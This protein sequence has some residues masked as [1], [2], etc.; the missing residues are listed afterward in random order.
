MP[1]CNITYCTVHMWFYI[2]LMSEGLKSGHY[3]S[4]MYLQAQRKKKYVLESRRL[5]YLNDTND[6]SISSL[7][8]IE[9]NILKGALTRRSTQPFTFPTKQSDQIAVISFMNCEDKSILHISYVNVLY[10]RCLCV[11]VPHGCTHTFL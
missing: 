8:S 5:C 3:T 4:N 1:N 6:S 2:M 10:S 7:H 11:E 9:L